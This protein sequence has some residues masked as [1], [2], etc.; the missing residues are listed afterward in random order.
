MRFVLQHAGE[1][2][3]YSCLERH[4]TSMGVDVGQLELLPSFSA[5]RHVFRLFA[6]GEHAEYFRARDQLPLSIR[7]ED[8]V[9]V[10]TDCIHVADF[11][12]ELGSNAVEL[13]I[14]LADTSAWSLFQ[15]SPDARGEVAGR[16]P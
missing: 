12:E 9:L 2:I 16:V 14:I 6:T 10:P 1:P 13:E 5:V 3:G 8:G 4:D 15:S 11:S 7:R